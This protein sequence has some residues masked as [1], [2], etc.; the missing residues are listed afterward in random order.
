MTVARLLLLPKRK[1][2]KTEHKKEINLENG[3]TILNSNIRLPNG[4]LFSTFVD[5]TADKIRDVT[6]QRLRE[7]IEA[8]PLAI[9]LWDE[10]DKLIMANRDMRRRA[11]KF[12]LKI[13]KFNENK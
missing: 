5:I 11:E 3:S 8:V 4:G 1:N 13:N 2:I 7:A 12:G 9:A 10:N 6:M